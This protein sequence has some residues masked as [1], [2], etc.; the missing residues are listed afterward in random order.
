[1][2]SYASNEELCTLDAVNHQFKALTTDPWKRITYERFGLKNGKDDWRLAV[3]FL[4]EPVFIHHDSTP[5]HDGMYYPGSPH[6]TTHNSLIAVLTDDVTPGDDTEAPVGI[7]LYD[8]ENLSHIGTRE[9]LGWRVTL[10]G[11]TGNE[12]F[13]TNTDS[14]LLEYSRV[15]YDFVQREHFARNFQQYEIPVLGS[16]THVIFVARNTLHLKRL[17]ISVEEQTFVTSCQSISLGSAHQ[18]IDEWFYN[19]IA[20]GPNRST[21]FVIYHSSAEMNEFSVWSLSAE[22]DQVSRTQTIEVEDIDLNQ[23]ALAD[24]YIIGTSHDKKIHVWDRTTGEK[25]PYV[26]CVM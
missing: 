12:L 11:P 7:N 14:V 10:A 16:E 4:R 24:E 20:W 5:D 22:S 18:N 17:A 9:S 15:G 3:S 26:S 19:S 23:V 25:K 2:F 8:A 6:V 21:E 1:M 13:V